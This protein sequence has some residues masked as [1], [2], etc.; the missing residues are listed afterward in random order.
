MPFSKVEDQIATAKRNASKSAIK[1]AKTYFGRL[2]ALACALRRAPKM[3]IRTFSSAGS[4]VPSSSATTSWA[5]ASNLAKAAASR[6]ASFSARRVLRRSFSAVRP[7]PSAVFAEVAAAM[8]GAS[9]D[10]LSSAGASTEVVRG[11]A[12]KT[13][14]AS[15]SF[16]AGGTPTVGVMIG[17]I[18]GWIVAVGLLSAVRVGAAVSTEVRARLEKTTGSTGSASSAGSSV[19]SGSASS[20]AGTASIAER[21]MSRSMSNSSSTCSSSAGVSTTGSTTSSSSASASTSCGS[22]SAIDSGSA[23]TSGVSSTTSGSGS[24]TRPTTTTALT[25]RSMVCP[26]VK[27]AAAALVRPKNA[28]P[29]KVKASGTAAKLMGLN[30]Y[31]AA[32]PSASSSVSRAIAAT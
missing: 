18:R 22:G 31:P 16:G 24:A 3:V 11:V 28:S 13:G 9:A 8:T 20:G 21:S 14:P 32:N 26:S 7:L 15:K 25:S 6:A 2:T 30:P 17:V 23:V 5:L 1:I 10:G 29:T 27:S 4:A 19:G 12:A